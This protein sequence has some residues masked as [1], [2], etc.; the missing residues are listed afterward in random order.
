MCQEVS[1]SILGEIPALLV[2][3]ADTASVYSEP[4][5][6]AQRGVSSAGGHSPVGEGDKRTRHDTVK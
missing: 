4:L 2:L 6:W 3:R 1:E 5:T